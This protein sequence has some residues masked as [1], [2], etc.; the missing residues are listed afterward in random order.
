VLTLRDSVGVPLI[1]FSQNDDNL[2]T[3]NTLLRDAGHPVHCVRINQL[4][5]LAEA[6][7]VEPPELVILFDEEPNSD[8][9]AVASQLSKLQPS[10]PLLIAR[11]QVNEQAIADAMESGAQ[12]VVSLTHRNRFQAVVD[13]ELQ[14]YRL[15]VALEKVLSSAN[16]HKQELKTLMAGSTEAIADVQ[17]G[18]IVSANPT[19][20]RLFG[21][22]DE[23]D[24]NGIPI[25]DICKESDQAAFKG[26]LVACLRG[27]WDE[28]K[29]R[30]TGSRADGS[31]IPLDFNLVGVSVE[32]EP[33]IRVI[34][35]GDTDTDN[36]PEELLEQAVCKDPSTGFF[37]RHFF[38]E[39]I[40]ARLSEQSSG[41]VRAVAYIRPD[42]FSRVHDDIGLLA[43][44]TLLIKLAALLQEF[45]QPQD[46]YGR[47]GGTMFVVLVERG[48]M[49][50]AE[51]WADQVRQATAN[52]VFEIEQQSTSL[53]CTV[54]LG[55]VDAQSTS[56]DG[57][58]S[59][60]EA[61]CRQGR[62]AGG[63]RVELIESSGDTWNIQQVDEFWVLR[64][65]AALM[66]NRLRLVHQPINSLNEVFDGVFDTRVRMLDEQGKLILPDEFMPAA[67]RANMVKN[68]DR[69]VIGATLSFCVTKSPSL[70]FVRLSRDSILDQGL[71]D[72]LVAQLNRTGVKPNQIC[73][74]VAEEI[75]AQHLTPT[76]S[77]AE[78]LQDAGFGFA[79][80]HLG[81][82]TDSESVLTQIPM[83]Y[84]KIDGSLM[85]GLSRDADIQKKVG[86][87]AQLANQM[88]IKTIAE[89]VED[90]NTMAVLWQLGIAFVQGNFIQAHGLVLED[91]HTIRGLALQTLAEG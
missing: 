52:H 61:A 67:A 57:I 83:E 60:V 56:I 62:D 7:E 11:Q 9:A 8:L 19:W 90:A 86:Q 17:E 27:K 70:V 20:V 51:T 43:T 91:T 69:W 30:L 29:L 37:H 85:Q 3:V 40:E 84:T 58:L 42:N 53:T 32:G 65:R 24:L 12:D 22:T 49:K 50:D 33:A 89:R 47:F 76:K 6:L 14:A 5:K 71:L 2:S 4:N 44:E 82:G 23:E 26:A 35:K 16:Q 25:M 34:I 74:Q 87:L 38:L 46:I 78:K 31:T 36:S 59:D 15:R 45:M 55:E 75:V 21:Y 81:T 64:L 77:M 88:G 73:F 48:T 18:I 13:R 72:W 63:N 79:V 10:P 80:D 1:V 54:A 39:K 28:P 66:N 41:G 68:V